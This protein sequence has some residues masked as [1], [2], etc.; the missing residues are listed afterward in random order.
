MGQKV[1]KSYLELMNLV[2]NINILTQDKDVVTKVGKKLQKIGNKAKVHLDI[3]NEK[4]DNLMLDN[5]HTDKDGVLILDEKGGYKFTKEGLKG[6][7]SSRKK[8]MDDTF[9]FDQLEFSSDG[10]EDYKFLHGWV[11]DILPLEVE[12]EN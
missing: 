3:Y 2:T 8:L 1:T 5:A 9:E 7:N 10:L 4:V 12:E 6:L 11:K